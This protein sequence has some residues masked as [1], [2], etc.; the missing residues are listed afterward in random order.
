[1][2]CQP[3]Q[4]WQ[5]NMQSNDQM[6]NTIRTSVKFSYY[7]NKRFKFTRI[8]MFD[9]F[10]LNFYGDYGSLPTPTYKGLK[11]HINVCLNKVTS[12]L[13]LTSFRQ[14]IRLALLKKIPAWGHKNLYICE[15]YLAIKLS[16]LLFTCH[17]IFLRI[18][19]SINYRYA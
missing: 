19:G 4:P 15:E 17:A 10:R 12:S 16:R 6:V 7:T 14:K 11:M 8:V 9:A 18:C 2:C 5:K 13:V 3:W 1:M